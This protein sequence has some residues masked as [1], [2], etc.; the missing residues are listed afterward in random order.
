MIIYN[1]TVSVDSL[2]ADEWLNWMR[3]KHIPDVMATA[4]FT[5]GKISRIQGEVE[6]E[7]TFS[8]M[9]LCDSE[10]LMKIYTEQHAPLLQKEHSEKFIGYFAAFRTLLTVIEE[11]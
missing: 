10:E 4:C 8:I 1:I 3:S 5:E 6:G 7:M 9:Y 11:F 2:K